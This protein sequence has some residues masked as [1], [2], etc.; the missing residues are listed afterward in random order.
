LITEKALQIVLN[1][2]RSTVSEDDPE[3]YWEAIILVVELAID[4]YGRELEV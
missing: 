4:L 1:L 2:A 3:D